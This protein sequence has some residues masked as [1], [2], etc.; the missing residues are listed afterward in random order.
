MEVGI[1]KICPL[2]LFISVPGTGIFNDISK[3]IEIL[4]HKNV[5]WLKF[6]ISIFLHFLYQII[7]QIKFMYYLKLSFKDFW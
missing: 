4:F 6:F 3:Y 1:S 7:W 2:F 5:I